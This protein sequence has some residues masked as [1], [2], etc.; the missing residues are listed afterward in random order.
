MVRRRWLF[1]GI[2]PL[3]GM[4][5]AEAADPKPLPLQYTATAND[6]LIRLAD[7]DRAFGVLDQFPPDRRAAVRANIENE[8]KRLVQR[9]VSAIGR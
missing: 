3:L 7:L 4:R 2:L 8:S 1:A 5:A 9:I 6:D